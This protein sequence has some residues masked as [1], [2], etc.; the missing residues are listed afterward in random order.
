MTPSQAITRITLT[1][2]LLILSACAA[3]TQLPSE[4]TSAGNVKNPDRSATA[5]TAPVIATAT[6]VPSTSTPI[7]PLPSAAAAGK[8]AVATYVDVNHNLH[9]WGPGAVAFW[10][11]ASTGDVQQALPSTDG[12]LVAYTRSADDQTYSLELVNADGTRARTLIS[13]EQF[14]AFS[15]PEGTTGTAPQKLQWRPGMHELAMSLRM[16]HEGPGALSGKELILINADDGSF[17]TPVIADA[18]FNFEYSP[19]GNFIAI[20]FSDGISL[21]PTAGDPYP[22]RFFKFQQVN[23]ASD[24]EYLPKL[25]WASDSTAFAFFVPPAEPFSTSPGDTRLIKVDAKDL[26][27]TTLLSTKMKYLFPKE[28]TSDLAF[29]AY[30]TLTTSSSN[31]VDLH[32][33]DLKANAD[34]IYPSGQKINRFLWSPDSVHFLFSSNDGIN[35]LAYLGQPGTSPTAISTVTSMRDAAWVDANH[36]LIV[37]KAASGW[38]IWYGQAGQVPVI[39]FS[40]SNTTDGFTSLAVNY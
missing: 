36:Y 30:T 19:N 38:K 7:P 9:A 21:Y 25:R 12:T 5:G 32:I 14:M 29:A 17:S 10:Q 35:A 20:S 26:S 39:L 11:I 37:D 3:P 23:T 34:E 27:V 22:D 2:L 8:S 31:A 33:A 1:A 24:Y 15:H 4:S 16:V 18:G 40:D 6:N 28:I 13:S